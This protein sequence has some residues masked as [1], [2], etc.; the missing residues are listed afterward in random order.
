MSVN[1][2]PETT[3]GRAAFCATIHL[4]LLLVG[5]A[6]AQKPL[7]TFTFDTYDIL[8]AENE[9][10]RTDAIQ[11]VADPV[12]AANKVVRFNVKATDTTSECGACQRAELKIYRGTWYA[13]M[14]KE[15]TYS[16]RIYIDP[17]WTFG[18][19]RWMTLLQWHDIPDG[20]DTASPTDAWRHP[21][22][23]VAIL[24]S[25][26]TVLWR[27]NS[28]PIQTEAVDQWNSEW[29]GQIAK[30]PNGR[31]WEGDATNDRGHWVRWWFIVRWDYTNN[32]FLK[33]WKDNTQIVDYKGPIGYNDV[34]G[35]TC[36]F[37]IYR[38]EKYSGSPYNGA[39]YDRTMYL[40]DYVVRE[41]VVLPSGVTPATVTGT[42]T[43]IITPTGVKPPSS[44][45][46]SKPPPPK[47]TP[48]GTA[49]PP[50]PTLTG[51]A[52]SSSQSPCP[53]CSPCATEKCSCTCACQSVP[54]RAKADVVADDTTDGDKNNSTCTC[55][56]DEC[57]DGTVACVMIGFT[58][59]LIGGILLTVVS[60]LVYIEIT[61]CRRPQLLHPKVAT[62]P[63]QLMSPL[64]KVTS[65]K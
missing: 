29:Q 32:G 58:I 14:M 43:G 10:K 15:Y 36:K 35:P 34:M 13:E 4:A 22:L 64:H 51:T 48:T 55:S 53:P 39:Y 5:Y 17:S 38:S 40:D 50:K 60:R 23:K 65:A 63:A 20:I 19:D 44:S 49:K 26:W 62:M 54:V 41:G 1:Y 27:W 9:V 37:G 33:V 18:G 21:I 3:M 61:K 16:T 46:S 7:Y 56:C 25:H 12:N 57:D 8:E 30:P 31:W 6:L 11:L 52:T 47:P 59:G 45:S 24:N 28:Q 2:K 42:I